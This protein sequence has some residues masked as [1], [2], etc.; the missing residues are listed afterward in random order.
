MNNTNNTFFIVLPSNTKTEDEV[1]GSSFL[2]SEAGATT[3]GESS[4]NRPNKFK[5]R[6][7][8]KLDF[9]KGSGSG[10]GTWLCGLH[11][12]VYPNRLF[13]FTYFIYKS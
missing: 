1:G 12:I 7:P 6:L 2:P 8:R 4:Q 11:S 9:G 3:M 5:V 10:G 13:F